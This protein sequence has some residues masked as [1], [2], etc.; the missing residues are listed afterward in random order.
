MMLDVLWVSTDA[1]GV[2]FNLIRD[3]SMNFMKTTNAFAL[4]VACVFAA[5]AQ[6]SVV[7]LAGFVSPTVIDF[8]DGNPADTPIGATYAA[9]G[10]SSTT[11]CG[12]HSFKTGAPAASEVAS[13]FFGPGCDNA[14][15]GPKEIN[16][17]STMVRVGFDITTNSSDDTTI[18]AYLGASLVGS[19]LFDTFGGGTDG[20]FAGIEFLGGFDRIVISSL[21]VTNGAF[22]IDNLRF[23]GGTTV[24]EPSS[25]GLLGVGLAALLLR[26]RQR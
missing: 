10:V 17:A 2:P 3:H 21:Q 18:T 4:A 13:N 5:S 26:R 25:F 14:P 23:E 20:S 12:G 11:L 22:S 6:A 16:F 24:P 8:N 19:E 9:L 1:V 7:T 15:Y